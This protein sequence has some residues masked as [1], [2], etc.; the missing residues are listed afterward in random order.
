[1]A[2]SRTVPTLCVPVKRIGPSMKP[3]SL[4][5]LMPVMSPLPFWLYVAANT[6]SQLPRGRGSMAVTPVRI[7][8]LPGTSFPSPSTS[9]TCPTAT[10]ATS[11]M[12]FIGPVCPGNGIPKSRPRGRV[13][14]VTVRVVALNTSP[15]ARPKYASTRVVSQFMDVLLNHGR[16]KL[17]QESRGARKIP[18]T[19]GGV[20]RLLRVLFCFVGASTSTGTHTYF[21]NVF[22]R[23]IQRQGRVM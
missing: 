2:A 6:A 7:G 10:P 5:Q 4:I 13:C 12:A 16:D 14:A 20:K 22:G 8:P 1:M 18:L 21:N 23:C 3:D 11:V 9:V 15:S 19:L 17:I